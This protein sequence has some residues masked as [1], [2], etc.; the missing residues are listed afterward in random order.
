MQYSYNSELT[1]VKPILLKILVFLLFLNILAIF[2]EYYL[3]SSEASTVASSY[4]VMYILSMFDFDVEKNFPTFF[5]AL[6]L[7]LSSL[8][9]F[10]IA[11]IAKGSN[12]PTHYKK[13]ILMSWL[14]VWL[15]LDELFALHELS[16]NPMRNLLQNALRNENIGFL[17]FAWIVPYV[18]ILVFV[19]LYF[20]RFVLSLPKNTLLSKYTIKFYCCWGYIFIRGSRNGDDRRRVHCSKRIRI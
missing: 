10:C 3:E 9:L 2:T 12:Q 20:F 14:F 19:V 5:S 8:L 13:W 15:A 6:N 4:T 11:K 1:H 16:V 17:H 7:L 18:S